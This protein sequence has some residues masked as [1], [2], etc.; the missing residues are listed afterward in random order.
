M[1]RLPAK[2]AELDAWTSLMHRY[3]TQSG[4]VTI[5]IVGK[6]VDLKEA[7]KS[8]N[9]ALVHGG[10]ANGVGVKLVYV[11]SEEVTPENAP[12]HLAGVDGVLVP[13]G[14]GTRGIEGKIAAIGYARENGVPFFG[15][16]LGMQCAVIEYARNVLGL[17]KA[18]SEEFDL[19][20]PDPVIYLMR[21]WFD[22]RTQKVEHRDTTSDKG[23]TMRL[24][25]Y[26]CVIK[27][28][29]KAAEAYGA[30]ET[31]ERH[32]HRYEFNKS[33]AAAFEDSGIVLSGLSPD[34]ELVEMVE[35]PSHPWFLG[36]QFHPEFKSNPMRS[37]P[38][39]RAFIK[40][41]KKRAK[42]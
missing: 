29:T 41:A 16:C 6:Y 2:Y 11:N 28:D 13:G 9:E 30:A 17:T 37:H 32:R 26:P 35:L 36:C 21:E 34:G 20:T 31:S 7:Y 33:Y 4:T 12:A 15:I 39:F 5:A 25:A 1:L 27:P 24:G 19:S 23:G 14:F 22:F 38:L 10:V 8:L 40:A 42:L 18:N 3:D